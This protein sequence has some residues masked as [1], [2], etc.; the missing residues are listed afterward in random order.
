VASSMRY[1]DGAPAAAICGSASAE[2][3]GDFVAV[4]RHQAETRSCVR[5]VVVRWE[6]CA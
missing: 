6:S 3:L 4:N 5:R 2:D 1:D